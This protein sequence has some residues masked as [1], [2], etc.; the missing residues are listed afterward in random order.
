MWQQAHVSDLEEE[1]TA[2]LEAIRF[3]HAKGWD[4]VIFE[5]DSST[6]VN[7]LSTQPHGAS[8][9]YVIVSVIKKQLSIN[10][11]FEVKFIR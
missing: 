10:S 9:F 1:V 7:A 6:L 11:N 8:E 4:Q 3:V 2:F 5:S